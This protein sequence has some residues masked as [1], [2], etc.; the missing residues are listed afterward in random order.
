MEGARGGQSN[1]RRVNRPLVPLPQGL[2]SLS[3]SAV[4]FT[5]NLTMMVQGWWAGREYYEY[6]TAYCGDEGNAND[7][8]NNRNKRK[9]DEKEEF[10]ECQ[11]YTQVGKKGVGQG[12][13]KETWEIYRDFYTWFN[14]VTIVK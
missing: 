9:E 10:D 7:N 12:W 8:N 13:G 5:Y 3:L 11:S 1:F 6:T 4:N 14:S 2:N